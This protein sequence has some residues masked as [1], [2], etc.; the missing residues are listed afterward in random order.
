MQVIDERCVDVPGGGILYDAAQL[1]KADESL[2]SVDAWAAKGAVERI[3]GGRGSIVLLNHEDRRWV[4]R[5]Y[6]RGG[7]IAKIAADRYFWLGAG[8]TRSFQEWRLLA[9]LYDLNLPV[10]RPIAA[11]YLRHGLAYSAD[12]MTEWIPNTRTVAELLIARELDETLLRGVGQTIARFHAAGVHHADLNANNILVRVESDPRAIEVFILDFDRG[13]IR[14]RGAW[15][16]QVLARLRRSFDKISQRA[17]VA[18]DDAQWQA[19][20]A[21]LGAA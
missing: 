18:F 2:F 9:R 4:L 20:L 10:P 13:R 1:R 19:L 5:H 11:R 16:Q 21:G 14:A 15:E 8:R 12:L 17:G 7:L 3:A 6:R